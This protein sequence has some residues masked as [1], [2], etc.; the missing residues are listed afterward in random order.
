MNIPDE[1]PLITLVALPAVPEPDWSQ[2]PE[3]ADYHA[4]EPTGVGVWIEG[5]VDGKP[6]HVFKYHWQHMNRNEYS[7]Y[8]LPFGIDWRMTLRRRPEVT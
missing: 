6:P 4:Y 7:G 2:A 5:D 8:E 3:E 1:V